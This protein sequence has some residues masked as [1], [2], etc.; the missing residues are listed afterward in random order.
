MRI[1]AHCKAIRQ[2]EEREVPMPRKILYTASTDAHLRSF[3]LPYLTELVRRGDAVTAAAAGDGHG[4]P[5][6]VRFLSVP[7][8]KRMLAPANLRCAEILARDIRENRYDVIVTHTSLA[9]F[10]TRLG[11]MRAGKGGAKVVNTVHGYLFDDDTPLPRRL[12]LLE[13]EKLTAPVTDQILVMNGA[14]EVIAR[15]NALCRGSVVMIPGMGVDTSRFAPAGDAERL[16]ARR[17]LGIAPE[18]G[19]LICAAE[20]SERKNQRMLLEAMALLP[21]DTVLLLPGPGALLGRCREKAAAM[22]LGERVRFPGQVEDVR[23]WLRAADVCVSASRSEGLPFHVMEAMCCALPCALTDVKGHRD[24]LSGSGAGLLT[25]F[26]DSDAM[27]EAIKKMLADPALR[28]EM[29]RKGRRYVQRFSLEAAMP[30]LLPL[31]EGQTGE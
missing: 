12:I 20:F 23:P 15:K 2:G 1:D 3:H 4:L 6:G 22:G 31:L 28:A 7:F 13:A 16:E 29:G 25:P 18:A 8:T 11:V 21:G 26:G 17:A 14:D 24:L 27:A 5:E 10:F 30:A 19:V 9:A